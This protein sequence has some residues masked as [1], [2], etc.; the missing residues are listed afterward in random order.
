MD[1]SPY[2][3]KYGEG[4]KIIISVIYILTPLALLGYRVYR[5]GEIPI[6]S[7]IFLIVLVFI[8]AGAYVIFGEKIMDKATD[9]AQELSSDGGNKNMEKGK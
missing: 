3:G 5:T 1:F 9:T 2:G 4:I 7:I 6:D 8:F